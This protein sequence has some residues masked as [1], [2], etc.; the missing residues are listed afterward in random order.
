VWASKILQE[1]R[2]FAPSND[3]NKP[4]L[5]DYL[6]NL[7]LGKTDYIFDDETRK[8][9]LSMFIEGVVLNS[10]VYSQTRMK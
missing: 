3:I 5:R 1:I 4:S 10:K 6:I 8:D 7:S 9:V 2:F